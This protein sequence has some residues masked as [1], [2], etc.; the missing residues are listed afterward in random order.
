M[1]KTILVIGAACSMFMSALAFASSTFDAVYGDCAD[2]ATVEAPYSLPALDAAVESAAKLQVA[3]VN[4]VSLLMKKRRHAEQSAL[5]VK[6]QTPE[7]LLPYE[8]GWRNAA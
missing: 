6:L 7:R 1:K 4:D 5:I 3:E 8:V 2:I